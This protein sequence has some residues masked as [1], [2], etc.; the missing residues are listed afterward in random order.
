MRRI[1]IQDIAPGHVDGPRCDTTCPHSHRLED[2]GVPICC[3]F[4]RPLRQDARRRL[5][6]CAECRVNEA[7][8]GLAE[9]TTVAEV[10]DWEG[11]RT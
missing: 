10:M 2:S 1:W 4:D 9:P 6:R 8:Y 5:L 7:L 11:E 3:A